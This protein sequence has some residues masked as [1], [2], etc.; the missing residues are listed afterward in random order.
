M[1][2]PLVL[3]VAVKADLGWSHFYGDTGAFGSDT[4][5]HGIIG[6]FRLAF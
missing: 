3:P 6:T 4:D 1:G 5:T 2:C